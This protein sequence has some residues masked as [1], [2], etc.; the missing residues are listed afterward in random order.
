VFEFPI[1]DIL[2]TFMLYEE[3]SYNAGGGGGGD[4]SGGA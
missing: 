4:G 1:G 3:D 2:V